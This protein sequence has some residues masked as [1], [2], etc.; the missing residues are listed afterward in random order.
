MN[1]RGYASLFAGF[2]MV[3]SFCSVASAH[4]AIVRQ[5]PESRGVREFE[6]QYGRVLA[7]GDF[8]GDG[9]EDLAVGV[10][11]EDIEGPTGTVFNCGAV[12]V[13]YGSETGIVPQGAQ[14]F[15]QD[16]LGYTSE[17]FDQFGLTLAVGNFN[18]DAYD[19]LAVGSPTEDFNG[20]N[21]PGNVIVIYGSAGGLDA[22][23]TALFSQANS[24]GNPENGDEFGG[25]LTAGDFN[26]D[27]RDDL[28]VGIPG[29]DLEIGATQLLDVGAVQIFFGS[30]TGLT[31]NGS[32]IL[33]DADTPGGA[34][35]GAGFGSALASGNFNGNA[36]DDLAVGAPETD[37]IGTQD[38]GAVYVYDGSA[39]GP[40]A[41][42]VFQV[43]GEQ[44]NN[45]GTVEDGLFG[46]SL[47][48]G[49]LGD[50]VYE[51]LAIGMPGFTTDPMFPEFGAMFV[52]YGSAGG[53]DTSDR[54][55]H[56]LASMLGANGNERMGTS[57]DC[58]D[59][60]GDGI[61]DLAGGAPG[62]GVMGLNGFVN[63]A[64]RVFVIE[65]NAGG[66]PTFQATITQLDQSNHFE[67][68]EP[69]DV[70]GGAIV[71]G[72]FAGGSRKALAAGVTGEDAN[73]APGTGES[74]VVNAGSVHIH[75]PWKQPANLS[76]LTSLVTDCDLNIVFSVKPFD[77]HAIA[78]VT[79]I[80]T[81]LLAAEATQPGCSPCLD[82]QNDIYQMP[83]VFDVGAN[84]GTIGGS[85]ANMCT[86]EFGNIELLMH[87][88]FLRSGNETAFSLADFVGTPGT[89]CLNTGCAD[90]PTFV[91]MMNDRAAELGMTRTS[92]TN[93]SGGIHGNFWPSPN[94]STAEDLA[95]LGY[96]AMLND[97]V[98]DITKKPSVNFIRSNGCAS[99]NGVMQTWNSG[100]FVVPGASSNSFPNAIGIKPGGNSLAS[101]TF[102]AAVDHPDGRLFAVALGS[103]TGGSRS[104]GSFG[105]VSNRRCDVLSLLQLG[106]TEYCNFPLAPTPTPAGSTNRYA[107]GTGSGDGQSVGFGMG[108][109][110]D[111]DMAVR[112]SLGAGTAAA[113]ATLVVDHSGNLVLKPGETATWKMDRFR[114]HNGIT[115]TNVS[116]ITAVIQHTFSQ[117]TQS[118]IETLAPGA[119]FR[120]PPYDAGSPQPDATLVLTNL[121]SVE[122]VDLEIMRAGFEH[123]V[124][125]T[126]ASS[127]FLLRVESSPR[128]GEEGMNVAL[129]GEDAAPGGTIMMDIVNTYGADQDLDGDFDMREFVAFQRCFDTTDADCLGWFDFDHNGA[130]DLL[131]FKTFD[132]LR[133]GP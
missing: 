111:Q 125:L 92:Y 21:S 45:N 119:V 131:D 97:R 35:V 20:L 99:P 11:W 68:P 98:R 116:A 29:E 73:P 15:T 94:L 100:I 33:T 85:L 61:D 62:D 18:G 13:S 43:L 48:T 82:Y 74:V 22:S 59:F 24:A 8:D 124:V 56:S 50:D 17:V 4:L 9:Y 90:L 51:D 118:G 104:C 122:T 16:N 86:G 58:G 2:G 32:Y 47:A 41:G 1:G 78:S 101:S 63:A 44:L 81:G 5:G 80:M 91:D 34:Q 38:G 12:V 79:K 117:P 129:L 6:D 77:R 28:A 69:G 67:T 132:E 39:S 60:N 72:A 19:D 84:G 114:R 108:D 53:L 130:I 126:A 25:A 106:T 57:I 102:V 10:P 14:I 55:V 23:N 123:D 71:F 40:L 89:T 3:M 128:N 30:A 27:N 133:T 120:I 112:L 76:C 70:H 113:A 31:S 7:A 93:P 75:M 64:G 95:I 127:E 52:L 83:N 105:N 65:S 66:V 96:N 49:R 109:V 115:V 87:G 37:I 121:N 26:N 42:S 54:S 110:E 88:L 103:A 36:Y 107:V 46:F